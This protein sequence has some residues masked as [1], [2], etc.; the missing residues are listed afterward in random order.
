MAEK[1]PPTTEEV[2]A[3][4]DL[5]LGMSP[6]DQEAWFREHP[7]YQGA[8]SADGRTINEYVPTAD[9]SL[10]G[11]EG[12]S[13]D[14]DPGVRKG[15]LAKKAEEAV[16]AAAA[17]QPIDPDF[18]GDGRTTID[19][20]EALKKAQRDSAQEI[21][22]KENR[23]LQETKQTVQDQ[24]DF[25]TGESEN[26]P[27]LLMEYTGGRAPTSLQIAQIMRTWNEYNPDAPVRTKDQLYARMKT[28]DA[29]TTSSI[30]DSAFYG[31]DPTLTYTVKLPS[32]QT[33]EVDASQVEAYKGTFTND[34]INKRT[35][36]QFVRTADKLGITSGSGQNGWQILAALAQAGGSIQN[37]V[38]GISAPAKTVRNSSDAAD[39]VANKRAGTPP[40]APPSH[41]GTLPGAAGLLPGQTIRNSS[42]AGQA[43]AGWRGEWG[44]FNTSI[45]RHALSFKEGQNMYGGN[46]MLAYVHALNP[47][48]AARVAN[49]KPDKLGQRD[50]RTFQ[51]LLLDGGFSQQALANMGYYALG[52]D[53]WT[54][55]GGGRRPTPTTEEEELT[56]SVRTLPDPDQIRQAAKDMYIRLFAAE[57][58]DAQLNSLVGTVSGAISGAADNQ[59]VS[60]DAQL[61]KA[62]EGLPI[63]DELYGN[64]PS[65]MTET[66]YQ[67]Q[68]RGGAQQLLGNEAPDPSVI[69]GGMRTGDYQT[70]LGQIAGSKQAWGN[71]TFLGR[72]AQAAQI[73]AGAT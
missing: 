52:L 57:P 41:V 59:A 61:R 4:I 22:T 46:D 48:V 10:E 8:R 12:L 63:Y 3:A 47:S 55:Q 7:E 21:A 36:T 66:E 26:V 39:V 72:L 32:G 19:E 18:D 27:P 14:I 54:G 38:M 33:V 34:R 53:E 45:N 29:P 1:R 2:D 42:E 30:V 9:R 58:T 43:V 40:D 28:T 25:A 64:M 44:T 31:G 56:G 17:N 23:P 65:G 51:Q 73:A 13:T 16:A 70:T 60:A 15:E 67:G 20:K 37:N 62:A 11:Y 6:L 69:Q 49:T 24:I 68:F 5:L 50:W 35:I 71:S